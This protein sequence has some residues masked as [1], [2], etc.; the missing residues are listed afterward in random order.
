MRACICGF[1]RL[2]SSVCRIIA[3]LV[4]FCDIINSRCCVALAEAAP[5]TAPM[6]E[7]GAKPGAKA[8]PAGKVEEKAEPDVRQAF[9]TACN[10]D[11]FTFSGWALDPATFAVIELTL[12]ACPSITQIRCVVRLL[13]CGSVLVLC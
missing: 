4:E 11:V 9:N 6:P 1:H 3:L 10:P 12:P 8:A 2:V 5:A 7:P 13:I